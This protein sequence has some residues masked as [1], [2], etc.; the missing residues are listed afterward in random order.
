MLQYT[1]LHMKESNIKTLLPHFVDKASH[2][3]PTPPHSGMPTLNLCRQEEPGIFS[4]VSS[5]K[6]RRGGRET[7]F[8]CGH[9]QRLR[10][11]ERVKVVDD[12]LH[13]SS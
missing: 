5:I 1:L 7:V 2:L 8:V 4:H 6:G 10:A 12:L 13:I 3:T 9:G 11:T